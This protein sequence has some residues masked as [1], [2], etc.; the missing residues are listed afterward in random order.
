VK[1]DSIIALRFSTLIR[2]AARA[3]SV[4]WL[5]CAFMTGG[6]SFAQQF[7]GE[8]PQGEA[9]SWA[10]AGV[11]NELA[12]I[13]SEGNFP[14]RFRERKTDTKGDTTREIIESRE[15]TVARLVQRN[16]QPITADEDAA[17]RERLSDDAASPETFLR[18]HRRDNAMRDSVLQL[19]RLMPHAMIF[20]YAQ[21]QPQPKGVEATQVVLDFHPDP[22]FKAP[23]MASDVLTGIQGRVW[24]DA[25]TQ[26][27]TRIEGKILHPI[28]FGFGFVARLFPGGT[29][30]FEQGPVG[31]DRWVYRHVEE[32][33]TVRAL[34][35]KTVPVNTEMTSW[36]FRL[37]PSLV[38]YQDAIKMLLAMPVPLR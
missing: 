19:V 24:I 11:R 5:V 6:V 27:M 4:A 12:I 25:Q 36:D 38:G 32:H 17:E 31:G 26:C 23:T 7:A 9:K 10:E 3:M 8:L 15:G 14:V 33:V 20:S 13:S 35:V 18:H 37:M 28:N 21:G 2:F 16:G 29:I 34:M 1:I 30:E 22:A